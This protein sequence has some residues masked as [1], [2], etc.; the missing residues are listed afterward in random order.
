M[1]LF[2][3]NKKFRSTELFHG[4]KTFLLKTMETHQL[5]VTVTLLE[6]DYWSFRLLTGLQ[7]RA[8]D[9]ECSDPRIAYFE[10][11]DPEFS[12]FA[13]VFVQNTTFV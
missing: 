7:K 6:S 4:N 3:E 12:K 8:P 5:K 13:I 1:E 9:V 11:C 10:I 2:Y